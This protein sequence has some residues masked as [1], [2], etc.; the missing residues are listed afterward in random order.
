MLSD[1]HV[2]LYI[3]SGSEDPNRN[4]PENI[5]LEIEP[6]FY[7]YLLDPKFFYPKKPEPKR[8]DPNRPRPEKNQTE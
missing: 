4:Q 7:K 1:L 3:L 2:G 6:K 5:Q 8:T